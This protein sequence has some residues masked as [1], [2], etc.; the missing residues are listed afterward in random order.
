MGRR[1]KWKKREMKLRLRAT[2]SNNET[3]RRRRRPWEDSTVEGKHSKH[4][5]N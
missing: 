5:G 2:S 3:G 4:L 1:Q